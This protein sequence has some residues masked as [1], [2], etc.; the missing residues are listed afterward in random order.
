M[1]FTEG[2]KKKSIPIVSGSHI[3]TPLSFMKEIINNSDGVL[4]SNYHS[5]T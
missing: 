2:K 5:H 1:L 3:K 4:F